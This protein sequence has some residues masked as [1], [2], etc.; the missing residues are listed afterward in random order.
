MAREINVGVLLR[1][2]GGATIFM[3]LASRR[4][5]GRAVLWEALS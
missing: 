2:R 1:G 5:I 3:R 4:Q